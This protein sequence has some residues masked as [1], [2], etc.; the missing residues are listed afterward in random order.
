MGE[1][2]PVGGEDVQANWGV[3]GSMSSWIL[4]SGGAWGLIRVR[5]VA[6]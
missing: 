6:R 4:V 5:W 2:R 3:T 1:A